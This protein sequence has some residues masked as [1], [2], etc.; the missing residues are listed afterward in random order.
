MKTGNATSKKTSLHSR[1]AGNRG[2]NNTGGSQGGASHSSH[3]PSIM[4]SERSNASGGG[5]GS[6]QRSREGVKRSA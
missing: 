2:V 1:N 3:P 6:K 5:R 4:R